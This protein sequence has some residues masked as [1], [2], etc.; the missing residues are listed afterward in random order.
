MKLFEI[1]DAS[2]ICPDGTDRLLGYLFYYER[3]HRFYVELMEELDEWEAPPMFLGHVKKKTYS[4]DS[5]WSMKWVRQR[6]IPVD[7]QNLGSILRDNHLKAYDEYRLLMLSEG[8]CAQ[9]EEYIRPAAT[10]M[11]PAEIRKRLDKKVS[12]LVVLSGTRILVCFRDGSA[13]IVDITS[14][15]G[16]GHLF[17]AVLSAPERFATVKVSPG[18]NGIEWDE[19]RSIPAEKL[20]RAGK[21]SEIRREDL[22]RYAGNRLVDTA[23]LTKLLHVTRQYISLLVKEKR[24]C[25]LP[26]DTTLPIFAK[27]EIEAELDV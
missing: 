25:P 4:I 19:E 17:D 2:Q 20:Y 21:R 22:L 18:D 3:S 24:L 12:D 1:R 11:L 14:L 16:D 9:D 10:D 27:A 23:A 6:I 5:V 15:A 8:R 7:R 13:R 26:S